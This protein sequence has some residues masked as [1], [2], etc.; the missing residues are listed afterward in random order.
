MGHGPLGP[1]LGLL[2]SRRVV[3]YLLFV[4]ATHDVTL[5]QGG[6]RKRENKML[7]LDD[8]RKLWV[9]EALDTVSEANAAVGVCGENFIVLAA[10][11]D[12]PDLSR[13]PS[14][15]RRKIIK[16][17]RCSVVARSGDDLDALPIIHDLQYACDLQR[18]YSG[19]EVIVVEL[20]SKVSAVQEMSMLS[21][22]KRP[23]HVS[24]L[25]AG[26]DYRS[27]A[28]LLYEAGPSGTDS[29]VDAY[30]I[31]RQSDLIH[32]FLAKNYN[33]SLCQ[34]EMVKLAI[35]ALLEVDVNV[36]VESG[37]KDIEVSVLS[38]NGLQY[39]TEA[40]IVA[41]VADEINPI[42]PADEITPS[43]PEIAEN[44][45]VDIKDIFSTVLKNVFAPEVEAGE[46]T[47][48]CS[49]KKRNRKNK[50]KKQGESHC[51]CDCC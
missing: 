6:R 48:T 50:K 34:Q 23:A 26:Y 7:V 2:V 47:G 10:E 41:I 21:L 40:E 5:H 17:D 4:Y 35:R 42:V 51:V 18:L 33:R 39:L 29:D 44:S 3:N 22:V 32:L 15:L 16:L 1:L 13:L 8:K 28:P 24:F 45:S 49:K 46:A 36:G 19:S 14:L 20:A 25:V 30:A 43:V 31:G 9:K 12:Y 11:N 27:L 38:R 37:A